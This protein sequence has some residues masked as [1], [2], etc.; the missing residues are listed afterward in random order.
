MISESSDTK[1][2][3]TNQAWLRPP[4]VKPDRIPSLRMETEEEPHPSQDIIMVDIYQKR[5]N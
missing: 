5:E 1:R 3:W 2:I 4:Q